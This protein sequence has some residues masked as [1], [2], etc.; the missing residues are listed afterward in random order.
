MREHV[1]VHRRGD[2]YRA[3]GRKVGRQQQVVGDAVRHLAQR[4]GRRGGDEQA[5]RPLAER[6]VGV[7]LPFSGL[8]NST[9]MGCFESVAMVSGVMNCLA[10]GSHYDF[11]L[12]ACAFEQAAEYAAL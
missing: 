3:A 6:D 2:R 11:H 12:G 5:V 4:I 1:Q 8:K 9:R 7:P 10:S